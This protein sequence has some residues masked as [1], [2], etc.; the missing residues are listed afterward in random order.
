MVAALT[1]F[2]GLIFIMF[3]Q[4]EIQDWAVT[5]STAAPVDPEADPAVSSRKRRYSG[6]GQM[7]PS[8]P[9][10]PGSYLSGVQSGCPVREVH[11][12][13]PTSH[14]VEGSKPKQ[15]LRRSATVEVGAFVRRVHSQAFSNL[16]F[17]DFP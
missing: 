10:V 6:D 3:A 13:P 12:L 9:Y 16:P 5:T 15:K 2:G 1:T 14:R 17:A 7:D 8:D 4:G 11:S